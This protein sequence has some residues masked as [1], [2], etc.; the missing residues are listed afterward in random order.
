MVGFVKQE[1]FLISFIATYNIFAIPL[2]IIVMQGLLVLFLTVKMY[3][4]LLFNSC[5]C[6]GHR[7]FFT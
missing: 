2:M 1:S 3:K 5:I 4:L 7:I 6:L